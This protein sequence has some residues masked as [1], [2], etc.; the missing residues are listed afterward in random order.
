M[1]CLSHENTRVR[2]GNLPMEYVKSSP[3]LLSFMDKYELKK[4]IVSALSH[5]DVKNM[6]NKCIASIEVCHQ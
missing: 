1:D 3:Y 6:G 4:R 2:L 5:S